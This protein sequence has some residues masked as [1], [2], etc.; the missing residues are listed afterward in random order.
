MFGRVALAFVT[1]AIL[2]QLGSIDNAVP[3]AAM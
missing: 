2:A 3:E 1:W